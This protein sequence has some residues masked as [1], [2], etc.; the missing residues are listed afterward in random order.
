MITPSRAGSLQQECKTL[1]PLPHG[2]GRG[3]LSTPFPSPTIRYLRE[4]LA[5]LSVHEGP[6][7][8]EEPSHSLT[9]R[10]KPAGYIPRESSLPATMTV[11]F[12]M[13]HTGLKWLGLGPIRGATPTAIMLIGVPTRLASI[14]TSLSNTKLRAF[15]CARSMFLNNVAG[16]NRNPDCV[17]S[18]S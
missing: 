1:H 3:N 4:D 13:S 12:A 5:S 2:C 10:Y 16:Y 17:S 8:D 6:S 9:T 14:R 11:I 15:P 7:A 18:M